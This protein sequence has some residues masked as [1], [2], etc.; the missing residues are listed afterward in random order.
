MD[1]LALRGPCGRRLM[2]DHDFAGGL[3]RDL[4]L[5]LWLIRRPGFAGLALLVSHVPA[6]PG[7]RS[8]SEAPPEDGYPPVGSDSQHEKL[9]RP[10]SWKHGLLPA[11]GRDHALVLTALH[12]NRREGLMNLRP[13]R[14]AR[15]MAATA[16]KRN[17]SKA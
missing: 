10:S 8:V 16:R 6:L 13:S 12:H 2:G 4:F 1:L 15:G 14:K 5:C 7:D 9:C 17:S 11:T 3:Q